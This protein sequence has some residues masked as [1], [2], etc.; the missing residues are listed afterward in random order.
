MRVNEPEDRSFIAYQQFLQASKLWWTRELYPRVLQR[1]QEVASRAARSGQSVDSE[2]DRE[3]NH[4]VDSD[5]IEATMRDDVLYQYFAWLERHLQRFKYSGRHGLVPNHEQTRDALL[6]QLAEIDGDP[7]LE[8]AEDFEVPRYFSSVD[9]HQH[10]G[11]VWQDE[12]AGF[13]YQRGARSSTPL[14]GK[15]ADLHDRFTA[16]VLE[17]AIPKRLLDLGCGFGKSTRPFYRTTPDLQVTGIDLAGPC[18]KLAALTAKDDNANNVRYLQRDASN[19]GLSVAS[20]DLVTSTMMI[21]EMPPPHIRS[22]IAESFRLLEAGGF[23]VHLDFLVPEQGFRRFVHY[24]HARRNNEPYMRPLNE[25]DLIAEHEKVGFSSVEVLS[26][27][28]ADGT[29]EPEFNAW[30]FPWAI[31]IARKP[32]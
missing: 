25:M 19:T 13:V 31:L 29:L 11:G 7:R 17:R 14:L 21:H 18:L 4:E 22:V 23:V 24:G 1:W 2:A 26:F 8:L 12:L 30:R 27:E 15:H 5:T 6:A 9:I 28:E 3:V 32:G 20:F 16:R 10:P